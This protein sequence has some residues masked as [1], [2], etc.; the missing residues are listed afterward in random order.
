MPYGYMIFIPPPI[1]WLSTVFDAL[2]MGRG[3]KFK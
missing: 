3:I 2:E 1:Q